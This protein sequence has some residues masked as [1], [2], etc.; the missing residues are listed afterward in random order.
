[1]SASLLEAPWFIT[2]Y[3]L[4]RCFLALFCF[5]LC[6]LTQQTQL[7]SSNF[8]SKAMR[9]KPLD[10]R[11]T[12]VAL[13]CETTIATVIAA[14]KT[15]DHQSQLLR[16]ARRYG[17]PVIFDSELLSGVLG[18]DDSLQSTESKSRLVATL[19][20]YSIVDT[21]TRAPSKRRSW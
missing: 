20:R 9:T 5:A 13:R 8:C 4:I 14:A 16:H 1:M 18:A 10:E 6:F 15:R 21:H 12:V 11:I 2:P 19:R 17:V 3:S 7:L